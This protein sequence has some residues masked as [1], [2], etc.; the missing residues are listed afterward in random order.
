MGNRKRTE[1]RCGPV[2]IGRWGYAVTI[3]IDPEAQADEPIL[4][5]SGEARR[6]VEILQKAI[7]EVEKD[8][9]G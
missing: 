1:R 8:E 6:L 4:F 2:F 9:N 3:R 5:T 7:G